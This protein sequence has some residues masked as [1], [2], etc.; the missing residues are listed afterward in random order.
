MKIITATVRLLSIALMILFL[1]VGCQNEG[2]SIAGPDN[3]VISSATLSKKKDAPAI[4]W[5]LVK[6]KVFRFNNGANQ[7]NGGNIKFPKGHKSKFVLED[8]SLTPPPNIAFGEDV[9]ITMQVDYDEDSGEMIFTFG[10]S[11]C[12]F[13]PAATIKLDYSVLGIDIPTLYYIDENGNYIEQPIEDINVNN[14]WIK[15]SVH[16]F[17]RYALARA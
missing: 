17:S 4:A 12:Q 16:H 14:K 7:Y 1:S 2:A 15:I 10:P 3:S 9:T 11:G 13:S 6:S 5:P 8:S